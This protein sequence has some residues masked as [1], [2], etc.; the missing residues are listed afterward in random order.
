[1]VYPLKSGEVM[2][3]SLYS[4]CQPYIESTTVLSDSSFVTNILKY[5]VIILV[6]NMGTILA[7]RGL[8]LESLSDHFKIRKAQSPTVPS[9]CMMLPIHN[10]P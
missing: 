7:G 8:L 5:P 4:T 1:M 3:G 9:V 6:L 10:Q 2:A